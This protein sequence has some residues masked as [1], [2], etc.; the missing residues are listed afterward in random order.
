MTADKRRKKKKERKKKKSI[1]SNF[2]LLFSN[3]GYKSIINLVGGKNVVLHVNEF[4]LN[5]QIMHTNAIHISS[6]WIYRSYYNHVNILFCCINLL[7]AKYV[8]NVQKCFMCF[9]K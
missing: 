5:F 8:H 1:F 9:V 7:F 4:D 6:W 2:F 3:T